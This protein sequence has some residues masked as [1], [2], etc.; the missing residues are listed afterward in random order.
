[1]KASRLTRVLTSSAVLRAVGTS[2]HRV[3]KPTI[4]LADLEDSAVVNGAYA[5]HV[6]TPAPARA[7]VQVARLPRNARVEIDAIALR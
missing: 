6:G 3:V 2:I 7:T 5:Q 4:Y 1:M